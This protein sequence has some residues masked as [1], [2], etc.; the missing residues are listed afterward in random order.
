MEQVHPPGSLNVFS[1]CRG[2]WP[3][4]RFSRSGGHQKSQDSYFGGMNIQRKCHRYLV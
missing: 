2:S 3:G 1:Q 4:Q